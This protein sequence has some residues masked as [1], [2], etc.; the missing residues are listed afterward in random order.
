M[1][2]NEINRRQFL[3]SSVWVQQ[4][5][6]VRMLCNVICS[7]TVV[8][9]SAAAGAVSAADLVLAEAASRPTRSCWPTTPRRRP[10]TGPR[11]CRC[12]SNR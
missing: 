4:N 5:K 10:G 2:Y 1:W 7:L 9:V 6:M 8:A 12:S 11:S 3:Q